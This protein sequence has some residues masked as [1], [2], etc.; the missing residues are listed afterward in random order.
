[1]PIQ[2]KQ[3]EVEIIPVIDLLNGCVVHAQRGQRSQ[4]RPIKT[5]LCDSSNPLDI[6]EA[7]LKLYPFRQLYIADLDAIQQQGSNASTVRSIKEK[8]PQLDIWLD[9]GFRCPLGL[10]A[11]Q[12]AGITCVL[13]SENLSNLTQFAEMTGNRQCAVMLSLDFGPRGY[14][15]PPELIDVPHLWPEKVILMTL[16]QVGSNAGPDLQTLQAILNLVLDRNPAPRIYAAGGIRH[17][18]D[19]VSLNAVGAAGVL[20]ATALHNG[21]ITPADIACLEP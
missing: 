15:G 16:A 18:A 9:G 13:G 14:M 5:P 19:I 3:V 17:L 21:S 11:W 7:L 20:V 12:G 8:H 4:Y 6:V 2:E 1:M 10:R